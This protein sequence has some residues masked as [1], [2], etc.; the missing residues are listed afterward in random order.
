M[1]FGSRFSSQCTITTGQPGH[2]YHQG[3]RKR[4]KVPLAQLISGRYKAAIQF[5]LKVKFFT[6]VHKFK[7]ER[8]PFVN[9]SDVMEKSSHQK[10]ETIGHLKDIDRYLDVFQAE[11]DLMKLKLAQQGI[12]WDA[13][14][15]DARKHKAKKKSKIKP[16]K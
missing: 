13:K 2:Q 11:L 6:T 3:K 10:L 8:Y 1:K 12:V 5:I 9:V 4:E 16:C 14:R 7:K 15:K